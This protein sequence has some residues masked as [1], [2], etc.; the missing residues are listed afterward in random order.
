MKAL[1][2]IK[3]Y[4]TAREFHSFALF[5]WFTNCLQERNL[6]LFKA[7]IKTKSNDFVL[8]IQKGTNVLQS[9]YKNLL[10]Q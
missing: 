6:N 4:G 1:V 2:Q 10:N 9:V 8:C 7:R 3:I 5:V